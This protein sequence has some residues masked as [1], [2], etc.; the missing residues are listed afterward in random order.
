MELT[1]F[2]DHFPHYICFGNELFKYIILATDLF[3]Q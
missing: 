2:S 1:V 3:S